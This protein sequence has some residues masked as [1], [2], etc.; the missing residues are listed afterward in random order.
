MLDTPLTSAEVDSAFRRVIEPIPVMPGYRWRL[1]G[2]LIGLVVLQVLYLLL[3]AVVVALTAAYT[4]A[5]LS[6]GISFNFLT[7]VL[8]LGPPL[9]GLIT[10]LFLL[11]PLIVRPPRP[12]KPLRI[13]PEDEPVLFE[14]VHRLCQVLGAPRPS[15][16]CADVQ[17]NASASL[18]GWRGF[19]L[20]DLRLTV[21]LPLATGLTLPQFTGVLAHEFGHFSQRA[22]LRTYFLVQT[23]LHW[24]RRVVEQRDHWDDWLARQQD[25]GDWRIKVVARIATGVVTLS[26]R[27][28]ALLMKAGQWLSC[29]FSR[30]TEFDADRHEAAVVGAN[31]FGETSI[32]LAWLAVGI[33]VAWQDAGQEWAIGRLPADVPALTAHRVDRFSDEFRQEIAEHELERT[34]APWDTHPS[35]SERIAGVRRWAADGVF[36]A[37]GGAMRLFR[38]LPGVSCRATARHYELQLGE[39]ALRARLV[40]VQDTVRESDDLRQFRLAAK[41]LFGAEVD[42][43][44]QWFRA[45]DVEPVEVPEYRIEWGTKAWDEALETN[46]LHFA[47]LTLAQSSVKVKPES[48]RL[49]SAGLDRIREQERASACV[50]LDVRDGYRLAAA[51]IAARMRAALRGLLAREIGIRVGEEWAGRVPDLSGA[52]VAYIALSQAQEEVLEIR[53]LLCALRVVRANLS[54]IP[55]AVCANLIEELTGRGLAACEAIIERAKAKQCSVILDPRAEP[56][57]GGQLSVDGPAVER[58]EQFVARYDTIAVRTLCQLAWFTLVADSEPENAAAAEGG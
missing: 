5:V 46:L 49:A 25:H 1:A 51:P 13:T 11:K 23:I 21:G 7:I 30:Q 18:Q 17:V 31:V 4:I 10:T 57:L 22:G 24:F 58:V 26:R 38:D 33:R 35:A 52:S 19:F 44:A 36:E 41:S 42:F 48:F 47:A 20:G 15:E 37:S 3:I 12:P 43:I 39:P 55:A 54:V 45:D 53:R 32:R 2:V 8:Y 34:S 29:G 27:Y 6:V 50:L 16:I 56:T 28:L 40:D 9:V 14:F